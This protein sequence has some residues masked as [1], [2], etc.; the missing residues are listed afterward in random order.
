MTPADHQRLRN[1]GNRSL[2][3]VAP[4][5]KGAVA[6][7][8]SITCSTSRFRVARR[9]FFGPVGRAFLHL[10]KKNAGC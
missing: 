3:V 1:A 9:L 7:S 2:P 10:V 4:E 5:R 6:D 8:R